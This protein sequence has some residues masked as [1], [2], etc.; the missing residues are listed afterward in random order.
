MIWLFFITPR[1]HDQLRSVWSAQQSSQVIP[2]WWVACESLENNLM[3]SDGNYPLW[4]LHLSLHS[5]LLGGHHTELIFIKIANNNNGLSSEY[6]KILQSQDVAPTTIF[7]WTT[8][9]KTFSSIKTGG[10]MTMMMT[11]MMTMVTMMSMMTPWWT[12]LSH[13]GGE[14]DD[15]SRG[16][17][18]QILSDYKW[19]SGVAKQLPTSIE[20]FLCSDVYWF[21]CSSISLEIS[22]W[23]WI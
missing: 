5:G 22:D 6:S 2:T 16:Q 8:F 4:Q 20:I 11:M 9:Q 13:C 17:L 10:G 1:Y 23:S 18:S 3:W 15:V 12:G 7:S 14:V 21:Q 19:Q